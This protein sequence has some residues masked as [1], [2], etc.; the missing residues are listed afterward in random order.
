MLKS[1]QWQVKVNVWSLYKK[2]D[3]HDARGCLNFATTDIKYWLYREVRKAAS[4]H[5]HPLI[6]VCAADEFI[7]NSNCST[8]FCSSRTQTVQEALSFFN[9]YKIL[10]ESLTSCKLKKNVQWAV[11]WL[12]LLLFL[13]PQMPLFSFVP[14]SLQNS[15][16]DCNKEN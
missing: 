7:L 12:S 8:S 16:N 15:Y 14:F 6:S 11:Q 4:L 2:K 3:I 13:D 10:W 9:C 5:K 1:S